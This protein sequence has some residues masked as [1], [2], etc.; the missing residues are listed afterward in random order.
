MLA[1]AMLGGNLD[2]ECRLRIQ[3]PAGAEARTYQLAILQR[4]KDQELGR[5]TWRLAPGAAV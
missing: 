3:L 4:E 5:I 2:A 1:E